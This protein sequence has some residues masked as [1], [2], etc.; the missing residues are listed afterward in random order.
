MNVSGA[1]RTHDVFSCHLYD[2]ATGFPT[3]RGGAEVVGGG[4]HR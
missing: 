4:E 2:E 1:T 3:R